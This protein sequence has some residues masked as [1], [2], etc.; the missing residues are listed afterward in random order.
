LLVIGANLVNY[1]RLFLQE[2]IDIQ[3]P[4]M[5]SAM[6]AAFLAGTLATPYGLSLW[7]FILVTRSYSAIPNP[8]LMP[9]EWFA[10]PNTLIVILLI[11]VSG[12][13]LRKKLDLGDGLT[14]LALL[15]IG[16]KCGR[17]IIY[18]YIFGCPLIGLAITTVLGTL[19]KKGWLQ[20]LSQ[21]IKTVA[22]SRFYPIAVVA[23]AILIETRAPVFLRC[24]IP[25]E[26]AKYIAAHGIDGNLFSDAQCGSYLIYT[27]HGAVPVFFDTRFDLYDPDFALRFIKAY[28]LGEGWKELFDQYKIA[29]A[30]LPNKIKLKEI[31]DAQPDWQMIY[32]DPD[33]SLYQRKK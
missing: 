20:Q 21:G 25:V 13:C 16:N 11:L 24:N 26:A 32:T 29:A 30:L 1:W 31:L 2:K 12:L 3:M 4:K 28:N 22:Q 18:F 27:S 7:Q 9:L 14:L 15:L 6:T 17:L 5:F 23:L 10:Q 33:F 19:F 8:E